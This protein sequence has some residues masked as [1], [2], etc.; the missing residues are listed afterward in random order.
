VV[1]ANT[2]RYANITYSLPSG[3]SPYRG[4]ANFLRRFSYSPAKGSFYENRVWATV[5][6]IFPAVYE[7]KEETNHLIGKRYNPTNF[8]LSE[9]PASRVHEIIGESMVDYC[10]TDPPYSN[11]IYFLDLSTLWAAWLGMEINPEA[12]QAELITKGTLNKSREQFEREFV[13][14]VESKT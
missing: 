9:L 3:R 5:E 13:V 8:V 7:A 4:N 6:R 12:R 1:L 14:S 11:D 2:V 10:F